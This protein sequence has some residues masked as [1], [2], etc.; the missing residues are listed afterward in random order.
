MVSPSTVTSTS[1]SGSSWSNSTDEVD[2]PY[3]RDEHGGERSPSWCA[4]EHEVDDGVGE[5]EEASERV[6]G[7]ATPLIVDGDERRCMLCNADDGESIALTLGMRVCDG[8]AKTELRADDTFDTSGIITGGGTTEVA[9]P[10]LLV[11][12][13]D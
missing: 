1:T 13:V 3:D 11:L 6:A 9:T 7:D 4:S 2:R 8:D 12:L 10:V 5:K